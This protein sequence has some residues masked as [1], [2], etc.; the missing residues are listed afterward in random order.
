MTVTSI[1][2]SSWLKT[3]E[4]CF[5][6]T[7]HVYRRTVGTLPHVVFREGRMLTKLPPFR[8]SPV[9]KTTA[10]HWLLKGLK[11]QYPKT[12]HRKTWHLGI[13]TILGWR[14]LRKCQKQE[15][16]SDLSL[17]SPLLS[18]KQEINLPG[19]STFPLYQEEGEILITRAEKAMWTNLNTPLPFTTHSPNPS[20]SSILH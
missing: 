10:N 16:R 19:K 4:V 8:M 11:T 1:P 3:T 14:G 20:V 2:K 18:W 15:G 7:L 13:L 17:L 12:Q 6:P 9:P 5:L